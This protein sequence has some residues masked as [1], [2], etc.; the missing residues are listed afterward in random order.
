MRVQKSSST[1]ADDNDKRID[2]A[3]SHLPGQDGTCPSTC[4]CSVLKEMTDFDKPLNLLGN[5]K[6]RTEE[7]RGVGSDVTR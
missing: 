3:K 6:P 1:A 2:L 5:D 7:N 4:S